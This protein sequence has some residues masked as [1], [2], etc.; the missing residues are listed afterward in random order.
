MILLVFALVIFFAL[1]LMPAVP[2]FREAMIARIGARAYKGAFS[3]ASLVTLGLV[4]WSYA[5]APLIHVWA[6]PYELR[7]LAMLAMAVAMVLAM[8]AF[9]PGSIRQRIAHPMLTAVIIWAAAH[10]LV[11][12]D[13][14]SMLLFGGF[15]VYASFNR[16]AARGRAE[17]FPVSVDGKARRNDVI[18]IVSGLALYAAFLFALHKWLIGVPV[19][20]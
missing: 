18:A 10:L 16:F 13:L 19:L 17:H 1:H 14:A 5:T 9:F 12:G 3:V 2:G 6:P 15:L 4:I 20:P 7:H 8:A 11:N